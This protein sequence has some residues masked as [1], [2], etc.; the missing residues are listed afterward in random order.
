MNGDDEPIMLVTAPLYE[1]KTILESAPD[2][3]ITLY[4]SGKPVDLDELIES[5]QNL[6]AW[7]KEN[8]V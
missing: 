1:S 2:G 6:K 7:V 4:V 5:L 8:G 3:K